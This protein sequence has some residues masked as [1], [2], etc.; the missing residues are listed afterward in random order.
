L[1]LDLFSALET[2]NTA[3]VK[4]AQ[5]RGRKS[6]L[7]PK[8]LDPRSKPQEWARGLA[9]AAMTTIVAKTI[10]RSQVNFALSERLST[11]PTASEG[12]RLRFGKP[13]EMT[14]APRSRNK[15]PFKTSDAP[16]S[17]NDKPQASTTR[18]TT[19]IDLTVSYAPFFAKEAKE[20]Y[21]KLAAQWAAEDN[22]MVKRSLAA[23]KASKA[24]MI[25]RKQ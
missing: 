22:A 2:A 3:S 19:R 1:L 9:D 7:P 24:M 11:P 4:M 12:S 25:A 10:V 13:L 17:L 14:D 16:R 21:D 5:Q 8:A 18:D 20:S 23:R 15:M 6:E